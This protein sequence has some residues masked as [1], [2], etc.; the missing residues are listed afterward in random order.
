MSL[1][2]FLDIKTYRSVEFNNL[3]ELMKLTFKNIA[4]CDETSLE[5]VYNKESGMHPYFGKII[6]ISLGYVGKDGVWRM[7]SLSST[8]ELDILTKFVALMEAFQSNGYHLGGFN[9][10]NF[11]SPFINNR[12]IANQLGIPDILSEYKKKP[13]DQCD[14]D[15]AT[16]YRFGLKSKIDLYSMANFLGVEIPNEI[17]ELS[18]W[19]KDLTA[20]VLKEVARNCEVRLNLIRN[21]Y[22][23]LTELV[24]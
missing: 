9:L 21:I 14:I 5:S 12:L 2:V 23:K 13:W 10:V 11:V 22:Y 15:L 16:D 18:Q 6:C 1:I 4:N 7:Q 24:K 3:S 19:D 17:G 8:N 20:E